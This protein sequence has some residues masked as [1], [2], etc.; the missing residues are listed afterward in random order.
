[1][2]RIRGTSDK[3]TNIPVAAKDQIRYWIIGPKTI[4]INKIIASNLLRGSDG[5]QSISWYVTT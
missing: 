4:K 5:E 3:A 2:K 1:M